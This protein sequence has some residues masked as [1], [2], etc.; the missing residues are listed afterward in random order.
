MIHFLRVGGITTAITL[1][2][3]LGFYDYTVC[4]FS[5]F[6][7]RPLTHE[8]IYEMASAVGGTWL[9]CGVYRILESYHSFRVS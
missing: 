1:Q 2:K 8:Q 9:V 4:E 5:G 7:S 3:Q 6:P